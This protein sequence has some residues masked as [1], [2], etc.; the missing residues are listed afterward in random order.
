M[1]DKPAV[2]PVGQYLTQRTCYT[3]LMQVVRKQFPTMDDVCEIDA[4]FNNLG[5]RQVES[6]INTFSG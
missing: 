2:N 6:E 3:L 1:A 5:V 4:L